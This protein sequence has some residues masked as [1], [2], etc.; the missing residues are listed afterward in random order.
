MIKFTII[1][2][3]TFDKLLERQATIKLDHSFVDGDVLAWVVAF[4][5]VVK[6]FCQEGP[7]LEERVIVRF[8]SWHSFLIVVEVEVLR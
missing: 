5:A 3:H 2:V 6:D 7:D 4:T 8:T 1:I